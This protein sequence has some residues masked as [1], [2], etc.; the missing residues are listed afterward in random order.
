[1]SCLRLFSFPGLCTLKPLPPNRQ[2]FYL[3]FKALGP[4]SF[5]LV[6]A[7][8]YLDLHMPIEHLHLDVPHTPQ[9]QPAPLESVFPARCRARTLG[10]TCAPSPPPPSSSKSPSPAS[11]TCKVLSSP[12]W[13][14]PGEVCTREQ[15]WQVVL[16]GLAGNSGPASEAEHPSTG[17]ALC[18]PLARKFAA[19]GIFAFPR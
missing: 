19:L 3:A 15:V 7:S 18:E 6:Q 13:A 10:A 1:M 11:L 5:V 9:T 17:L 2:T 16:A 14:H 4:V 8:L 12:F